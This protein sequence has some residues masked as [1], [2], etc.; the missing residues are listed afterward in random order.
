[1][2]CAISRAQRRRCARVP[3][4]VRHQAER[5]LP[6]RPR[7][8]CASVGRIARRHRLRE[9]GGLD[10]RHL[11][12]HAAARSANSSPAGWRRGC[13]RSSIRRPHTDP[14]AAMR[15]RAVDQDAAHR[16]VHRRHAPGSA[17][18]PDRRPGTLRPVRRSAAGARAAW[19]RPGGAGPDAR[20]SRAGRRS[21][22]PS[23]ARARRPGSGGRAARAPWPCCAASAR[24][25]RGR[26]PA[27]S[28]SRPC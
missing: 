8:A 25:A 1:M 11:A 28:G 4:V 26:S 22:G 16:V 7:P 6:A 18:A 21:C 14:A 10:A 9:V 20:P 17:P 2:V 19:L 15:S 27:G 3:P 5:A 24:P 12:E 13:R 23:A